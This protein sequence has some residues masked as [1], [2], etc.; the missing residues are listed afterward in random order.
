MA[1]YA[2]HIRDR[3]DHQDLDVYKTVLELY[4]NG[5]EKTGIF[6]GEI[7]QRLA[8]NSFIETNFMQIDVSMDRVV[9][10]FTDKESVTFLSVMGSMAALLNLWVGIT[11]IT[12]VEI[13]DFFLALVLNKIEPKKSGPQPSDNARTQALK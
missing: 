2:S 5:T 10:H 1:V 4:E 8:R 6:H 11:F 12:G 3:L 9:R 7:A 13:I